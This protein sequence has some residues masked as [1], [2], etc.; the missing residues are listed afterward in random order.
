MFAEIR[1]ERSAVYR[2]AFRRITAIGPIQ[3]PVLSIDFEIDRLRQTIEQQFD[4]CSVRRRLAFRNV[5]VCTKDA[6]LAR[7]VR[8]FLSPIKLSAVWID[9]YPN[10]PFRLIS[11]W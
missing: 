1:V 8:T 10:A 3:E 7:I 6:A 9:G 11:S 4:V 2:V 5:D